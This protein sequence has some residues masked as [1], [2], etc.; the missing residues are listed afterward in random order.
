MADIE[1]KLGFGEVPID[2]S[3]WFLKAPLYHSE[4]YRFDKYLEFGFEKYRENLLAVVFPKITIDVYCVKCGRETVFVPPADR[5]VDWFGAQGSKIVRN[6]ICYAHFECSRGHCGNPL[7]FIFDVRAGRITKIG[8]LPSIADLVKPDLQKFRRVLTEEQL[9]NWQRAVGLRAHGVG[10]GSYVYLRRI[11]EQLI[12]AAK[13]NAG[14]SI[15]AE[16]YKKARW[17]E[18][19]KLLSNY[20]PSYLVEN[21]A[22][23]AVLSK[24][25]HELSE[26]E[27]A[28]YFDVMHTAMELICEDKLAAIQR[29]EKAKAGAKALQQVLSSLAGKSS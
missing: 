25:V 1:Y 12:E 3:F 5:K 29:E 10:A 11:I 7:Y 23:Y 13:V 24:G 26:D 2:P 6:G 22:V 19:I 4:D 8:Q 17:P 9:A 28:N 15:D 18:R 27:C 14:K 20:L 21:A 16:T